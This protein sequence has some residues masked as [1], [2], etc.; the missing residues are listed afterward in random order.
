[1]DFATVIVTL[2]GIVLI[3]FMRWFFLGK[4]GKSRGTEGDCYIQDAPE[5]GCAFV[6]GRALVVV[7]KQTLA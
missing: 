5:M 7:A 1:M 2:A 6:I 4:K 3:I